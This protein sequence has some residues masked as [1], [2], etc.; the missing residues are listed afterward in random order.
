LASLWG[1]TNIRNEPRSA[2]VLS[3]PSRCVGPWLV[4]P[5][6]RSQARRSLVSRS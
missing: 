3:V 2:R 6:E 4:Y 5:T 1:R